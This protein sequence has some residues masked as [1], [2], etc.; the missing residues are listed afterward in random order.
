MR[1][2]FIFLRYQAAI[3]VDGAF[4]QAFTLAKQALKKR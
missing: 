4:E 2:V 3:F 1:T